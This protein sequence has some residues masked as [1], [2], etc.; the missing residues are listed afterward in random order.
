MLL[1]RYPIRRGGRDLCNLVPKQSEIVLSAS[2][3]TAPEQ[4]PAASK[5]EARSGIDLPDQGRDDLAQKPGT[6]DEFK[7]LFEPRSKSSVV[8]RWD[9]H[10]WQ[11][12]CALLTPAAVWYMLERTTDS[13]KRYEEEMEAK[14]ARQQA[15]ETVA[16]EAQTHIDGRP[17]PQQQVQQRLQELETELMQLHA[18]QFLNEASGQGIQLKVIAQ[19]HGN[20]PN[21]KTATMN[22]T[23][24]SEAEQ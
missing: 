7:V 15:A 24:S 14:D 2:V 19:A 18:R 3:S 21:A 1:L 4:T 8:G 22:P 23:I 13:M 20:V 16:A 6:W 17:D 5:E 11:F 10:A 12:F 9:W